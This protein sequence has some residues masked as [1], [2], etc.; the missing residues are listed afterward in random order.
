LSDEFEIVFELHGSK[1]TE[2]DETHT[3]R[4]QP[5]FEIGQRLLASA[6]LLHPHLRSA[7]A[8]V[9]YRNATTTSAVPQMLSDDFDDEHGAASSAPTPARFELQEDPSFWKDNNVQV[10]SLPPRLELLPLRFLYCSGGS[11]VCVREHFVEHLVVW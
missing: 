7:A 9:R 4:T 3:A 11:G 2:L 10:G 5:K 8:P 1:S 6:V